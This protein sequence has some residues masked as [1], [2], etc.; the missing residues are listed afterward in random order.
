MVT[1][2]VPSDPPLSIEPI[3]GWRVWRLMDDE[4]EPRLSSVIRSELWPPGDA[5]LARCQTHGDAPL[6]K[7]TCGLYAASSPEDLARAGVFTSEVSVVG[8]VAMWGTVVEHARGARS[9][10]AY[11]VRVR[12]VCGPC[13]AWGRGAVAPSFV[14]ASDRG[15][16]AVC[17]W[18]RLTTKGLSQDASIVQHRLLDAY[19]VDLLPTG[20]LR[21]RLRVPN[22]TATGSVGELI[23]LLVTVVFRLLGFLMSVVMFLLIAGVVVQIVMGAARVLLSLLG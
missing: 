4:G 20:H 7:C 9:R 1:S 17:R 15:P 14:V 6:L 13:L 11:P 16:V 23:V 3:L 5:S 2:P 18:H 21:R 8:A 10:F 22:F 12:L 19:G